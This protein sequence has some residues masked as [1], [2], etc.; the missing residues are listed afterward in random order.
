MRATK[1]HFEFIA[2]LCSPCVPNAGS[3]DSVNPNG[4][5]C[6]DV[7]ADWRYDYGDRS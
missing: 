7:P 6:Y 4:Y 2:D 5:E 1:Q 3:L